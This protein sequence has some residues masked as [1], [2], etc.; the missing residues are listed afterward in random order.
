MRTDLGTQA[1]HYIK[2]LAF[3]P[4]LTAQKSSQVVNDSLAPLMQVSPRDSVSAAAAAA[5]H[6][7]T[8]GHA[9]TGHASAHAIHRA[10]LV[11]ALADGLIELTGIAARRD[12]R[13]G[14]RHAHAAGRILA[15]PE[16]LAGCVSVASLQLGATLFLDAGHAHA[17]HLTG[18]A[19]VGPWARR[20]GARHIGG[21]RRA[22]AGACRT[23]NAT[24]SANA[25]RRR[26]TTAG[27]C[28]HIRNVGTARDQTTR[29]DKRRTHKNRTRPNLKNSTD[30]HGRENTREGRTRR[31][32]RSI[33]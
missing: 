32:V 20:R 25:D 14:A 2:R 18:R 16:T 15:V 10:L 21:R 13:L 27:G 22:S 26:S 8:A 5:G 11:S 29:H 6:A 1:P 4:A 23:A 31:E 28:R 24:R 30:H 19:D 7:A 9:T 3:R 12:A 17:I 33:N